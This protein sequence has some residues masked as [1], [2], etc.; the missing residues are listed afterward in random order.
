MQNA[1]VTGTVV[2]VAA[3]IL[4][5]VI[6]SNRSALAESLVVRRTLGLL[7]RLGLLAASPAESADDVL[8]GKHARR[9][10]VVTTNAVVANSMT[11]MTSCPRTSVVN[12]WPVT[13]PLPG[14]LLKR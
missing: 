11:S 2:A 3:V 13:R 8:K 1:L 7:D 4:L 6:T 5:I 10:A 9:G 12:S 14:S